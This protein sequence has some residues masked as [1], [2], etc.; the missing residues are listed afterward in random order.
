[1]VPSD[2]VEQQRSGSPSGV[3]HPGGQEA[4]LGVD[5]GCAGQLQGGHGGQT[6]LSGSHAGHAHAQ[7]G[8]EDPPELLELLVPEEPRVLPPPMHS[9]LPSG[10]VMQQL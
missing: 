5:G 4:Q 6:P 2:A 3:C 1:M 10:F 9:P 8:V 7:P